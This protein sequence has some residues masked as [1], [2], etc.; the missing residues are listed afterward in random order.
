MTYQGCLILTRSICQSLQSGWTVCLCC[1]LVQ[2][3]LGAVKSYNDRRGFGFVA[4]GLADDVEGT[5]GVLF[6]FAICCALGH[7]LESR[8]PA[9][10]QVLR[11]QQSSGEMYRGLQERMNGPGEFGSV[12]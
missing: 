1:L 11:R 3:Y 4:C 12:V 6:A 9:R 7:G 5:L 8:E 10:T 2:V